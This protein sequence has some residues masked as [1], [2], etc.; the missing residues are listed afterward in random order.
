MSSVYEIFSYTE[1]N[2]VLQFLKY[3]WEQRKLG[4]VLSM[5]IQNN[6]LSR[7]Q[8][9][10]EM[11]TVKNIHY[12]DIL[13]KYHSLVAPTTD[14]IPNISDDIFS[15]SEANLLVQ[16]D[17]IFADT[18]E[19]Q[20]TGKAV[21]IGDLKGVNVVAGLHTIPCRPTIDFARTY[22]GHYLNSNSFHEQLLPLL[23]GIKV[24]SLSRANLKKCTINFPRN[25]T[26]QER[27]GNILTHIDR[28][29]TLQQR[30]P[31]LLVL[32]KSG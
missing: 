28:L 6:T 9:S 26:E 27:I 4:D 8:L 17:V 3:S 15:V 5:S 2:C 18:A 22:L 11:G 24:L 20:T 21:E 1:L 30:K 23:Q 25:R 19:D 32:A 29:I 14:K 13:V 10:Y 31:D 7:A 16:G 12:G